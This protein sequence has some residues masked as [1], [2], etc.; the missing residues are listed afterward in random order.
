M[1]LGWGVPMYVFGCGM[2]WK[3][4]ALTVATAFGLAVICALCSFGFAAGMVAYMD[5]KLGPFKDLALTAAWG[6]E[7]ST[8]PK[9]P[10]DTWAEIGDKQSFALK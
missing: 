6:R 10:F 3:L 5:K 7:G 9:R 4:H 2:F 8:R 1:A